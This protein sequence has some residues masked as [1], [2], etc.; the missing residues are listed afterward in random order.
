MKRFISKREREKGTKR[1]QIIIG[2]GLAFL[3]VL[4]VLGFALQG[5]NNQE[6]DNSLDDVIY[7]GFE[8]KY[9]NGLWTLESFVFRY[10]PEQVPDIGFDLKDATFYQGKPVYIYSESEEAELEV[11]TNLGL[12]AQ[13]IQDACIENEECFGD[14]PVKTCEDNFIIIKENNNSMI[15]QDNNCVYIKGL[16]EDLTKLSDQFLFKILGI[17]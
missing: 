16:Q 7:N 12:V 5:G 13:R 9:N 10:T 8:F 11:Y 17:R 2:V 1:K 15:T 14:F 4:S 3:M 6:N